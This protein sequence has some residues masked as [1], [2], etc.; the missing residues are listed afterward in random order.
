[1]SK[2]DS[3]SDSD[4]DVILDLSVNL[5]TNIL[6][7]S[8]IH[9]ELTTKQIREGYDCCDELVKILDKFDPEGN[10]GLDS[11][12]LVV[13]VY[14]HLKD[15][16]TENHAVLYRIGFSIV[17][18]TIGLAARL[19]SGEEKD[20]GK[21]VN[22]LLPEHMENLR[23]RLQGILP[24]GVIK[25]VLDLVTDTIEE[26][27]LDIDISDLLIQ[28]FNKVAFSPE[29]RAVTVIMGGE[30]KTFQSFT[31]LIGG[32]LNYSVGQFTKVCVSPEDFNNEEK[33][34]ETTGIIAH[35]FLDKNRLALNDHKDSFI[36]ELIQGRQTG[37]PEGPLSTDELVL[38]GIR[39]MAEEFWLKRQQQQKDIP[40]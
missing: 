1:M 4:V 37:V 13:M 10:K 2:W 26:A 21:T 17:Q 11:K 12:R 30:R 18:Q 29:G 36:E 38:A 8:G 25:G 16:Y 19:S 5:G 31:E 34:M 7:W 20:S 33:F 6:M 40:N 15:N 24:P 9:G 32:L 28:V 39:G 14:G 3:I 27:G 35:D 23:G 22:D